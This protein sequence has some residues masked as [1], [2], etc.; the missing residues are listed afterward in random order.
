LGHQQQQECQYINSRDANNIRDTDN[1]R[2]V[3]NSRDNT[4]VRITI[5]IVEVT[6][7]SEVMVVTTETLAIEVTPE[8]PTA[9]EQ[10]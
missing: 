1:S 5:S 8:K 3:N 4:N 10:Q 7:T 6:S 2:C 9:V